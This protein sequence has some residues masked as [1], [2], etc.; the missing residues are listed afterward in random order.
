MQSLLF[1]ILL[2]SCF[3][4]SQ[5]DPIFNVLKYGA[6]GNGH[7]D[8]SQVRGTLRA[9]KDI[10]AWKWPSSKK[11]TWL[12]FSYIKGLVLDGRGLYDGQGTPWWSCFKKSQCHDRPRAISFHACKGLK[13][14]KVRV[15]NSPGGHLSINGCN[16]TVIPNIYLCAP[17]DSPNTGGIGISGSSHVTIRDSVFEVGDDC[18]AINGGSHL[19]ISRIFCR[20]GHGISIASLGIGG[21][22][23]AVEEVHVKNCTFTRTSNGA[24]IKTWEGGYGY[25]RKVTFED[26]LMKDVQHPVLIDQYYTAFHANRNM[27]A[28][29]ISDITFRNLRGTS[30]LPEAVKLMCD[31]AVGCTNLWLDNIKITSSDPKMKTKATCSNAHGSSFPSN[32]PQVSCLQK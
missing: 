31:K 19:N 20:P 24:R 25:V 28:I 1:A 9:P 7:T 8:D 12:Q 3:V 13:I 21:T 15:I 16:G 30:A 29:K 6:S 10:N 2:L 5:A 32:I 14:N 17:D 27:K 18:V 26:I 4:A 22:Y 11:E 23:G